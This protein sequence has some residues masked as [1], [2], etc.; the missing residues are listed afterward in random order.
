MPRHTQN[1][2]IL[3]KCWPASKLIRLVYFGKMPAEK[4]YDWPFWS[5]AEEIVKGV[6]VPKEE[7]DR[8]HDW[9][10]NPMAALPNWMCAVGKSEG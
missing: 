6:T 8:M 2:I 9:K 4:D 1:L 7:V 5:S 10:F 3:I